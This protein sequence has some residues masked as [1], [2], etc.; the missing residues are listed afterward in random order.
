M[1]SKLDD[2]SM[3]I[4]RMEAEMAG[5]RR[6]L[7]ASELRAVDHRSGVHHRMN[8]IVGE[9]GEVKQDIVAIKADVTAVKEDV[10]E[11][12]P[13][14]DDVRRWRQMGLGAL[15]VVGIGGAAVGYA[16]TSPIDWLLKIVAKQ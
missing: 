8:E 13:V 5:L 3:A 7:Q 14:T 15:G 12:K 6:D 2:I 1:T 10:S 9:I 11:V 16:L 4:G